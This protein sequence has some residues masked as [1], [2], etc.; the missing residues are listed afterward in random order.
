METERVLHLL[1]L[2]KQYAL[3]QR[4]FHQQPINKE[5]AEALDIAR[6]AVGAIEQIRW[7]RDMLQE[8]RT[9]KKPGYIRSNYFCDSCGYKFSRFYHY[10]P[11]CGQ[12]IDWSADNG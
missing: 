8:Y 4:G 7:E 6:N 3:K 12:A 1:E 9:P 11:D 5:V 10:C 2:E